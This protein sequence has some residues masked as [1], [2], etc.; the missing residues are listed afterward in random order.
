MDSS[1]SG[2]DGSGSFSSSPTHEHE[3]IRRS[4]SLYLLV[5][6][7]LFSGTIATAAVATIPA[8]DVGAHGFDKWDA[9]L[10]ITIAA[11]KASLVATVFMHLKHERRLVYVVIS[12]GV[13]H[14]A[15]FFMGTYL[16]LSRITN[17]VYFYHP[18][19][20]QQPMVNSSD[21]AK[22]SDSR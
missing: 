18:E 20:S 10:G 16:H 17:D 8:L 5:G 7:I 15:G 6:L 19:E 14:A 22:V 9:M 4:I 1:D 2:K 21:V 13:L 12:F 3:E 11:I